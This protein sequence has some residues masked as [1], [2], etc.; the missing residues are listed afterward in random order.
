MPLIDHL[1][2]LRNRVVTIA[3]ALAAGMTAGFIFFGPGLARH[4][5]PAVLGDD[6][7][8][9]GLPHAGGQ[10][11]GPE[12]PAG[13][14]LPAGEGRADRRGDRVLAG[15]AVPDLGVRRARPARQGK[16]VGL[17]VPRC[18]HPAV[19]HRHHA[20]LPVAGPVH[21]LPARP[22]AGRR[23]E[24]DPGRPV[25]ELRDGDDAGLRAGVRGAAAD[26]HAEPGRDLD[27]RAVRQVAAGADLRR[28]PDRGGGQPEPGPGH[29]ADPRRDLRGAGRG[30]RVHRVVPRPAPGPA[31]P[32]PLRGPGRRRAVP[33]AAPAAGKGAERCSTCP[34]PSCWSSR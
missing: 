28:I 27:S 12:R 16:A 22:D 29:H 3:L 33:A 10:P 17:P 30:G 13:R 26:R 7:R 24:P 19:R 8:A 34:S 21:A 9:L 23:A 25:P 4:R 31:A 2:E 20:V 32:R 6:P 5:A 15:L 1:R 18:G 14:V 11:A